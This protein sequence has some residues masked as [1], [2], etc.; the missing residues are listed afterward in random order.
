MAM[1]QSTIHKWLEKNGEGASIEIHG[2]NGMV[3]TLILDAPPGRMW[4]ES[5]SHITCNLHGHDGTVTPRWEDV[6]EN[7]ERVMEM[8]TYPYTDEEC[9]YC[10]RH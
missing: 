8:G 4:N 6:L 2:G 9:E 5:M 10:D 7:V 1:K 3:W